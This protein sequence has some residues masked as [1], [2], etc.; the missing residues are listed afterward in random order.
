MRGN[1]CARGR[2][3]WRLAVALGIASGLLG[4]GVAH[5]AVRP[6][7]AAEIKR[8]YRAVAMAEYFGRAPAVC[9]RLTAAGIRAYTHGRSTCAATF[10][11]DK[12]AFT[13]KFGGASRSYG[14][15]MWRHEVTAAVARLRIRPSRGQT[16]VTDTTHVFTATRLVRVGRSWKFSSAPPLP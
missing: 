4:A 5:A 8:D 11:A 15:R 2:R 10:A 14:A 13:A 6:S 12:H 7:T 1:G 16:G 3:T 9:S